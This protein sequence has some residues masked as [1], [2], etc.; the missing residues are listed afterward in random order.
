M[1]DVIIKSSIIHGRG[2]YATRLFQKGE[3]VLKW[4][5]TR[6]LNQ[7]E[8][9][10]LSDT[11]HPYVEFQDNKILLMGEPERYVNHPAIP[12][13]YQTTNVTLLCV[14]SRWAKKSPPITQ[15]SLYPMEAFAVV[16]VLRTAAD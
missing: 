6:E 15:I 10:T 8:L 2:L 11:E 16:A 12:T 5:N 14:I 7:A 9:E 3:A 13:R 1:P 4:D